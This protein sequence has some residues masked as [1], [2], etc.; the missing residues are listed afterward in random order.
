MPDTFAYKDAE[1]ALKVVRCGCGNPSSHSNAICPTPR[2]ENDLGVVAYIAKN[3]LKRL[4]W[5]L[6]GLPRSIRRIK[7][8][9]KRS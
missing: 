5:N 9:N 4:W 2:D 1:I 6:Y 7:K 8:S 3:P